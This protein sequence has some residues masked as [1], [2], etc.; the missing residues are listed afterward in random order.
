MFVMVVVVVRNEGGH[1]AKHVKL[2]DGIVKIGKLRRIFDACFFG[3]LF[4]GH[5]HQHLSS[6]Y[7]PFRRRFP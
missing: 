5:Q 3:K 6:Q 1:S 4:T 2:G 7:R